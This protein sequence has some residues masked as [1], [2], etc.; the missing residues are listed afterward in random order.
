MLLA[1][2]T[3]ERTFFLDYESRLKFDD[4]LLKMR[5]E[6]EA[7]KEQLRRELIVRYNVQPPATKAATP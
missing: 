7:R 1:C 2:F 5:A 4:T 3:M 6:F